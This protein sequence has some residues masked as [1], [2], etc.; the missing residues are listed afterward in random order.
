MWNYQVYSPGRGLKGKKKKWY[1]LKRPSLGNEE[2]DP[3]VGC[4]SPAGQ[5]RVDGTN[6]K[7]GGAWILLVNS[8]QTLA[9]SW[10]RA[11]MAIE[12]PAGWL[13]S[14]N[15]PIQAL[16]W[17]EQMLWHLLFCIEAL[18]WR[19]ICHDHGKIILERLWELNLCS[20]R[21]QWGSHYWQ[22]HRWKSE[23][24]QISKNHVP[25][26]KIPTQAPLTPALVSSRT[27]YM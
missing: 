1:Y 20:I 23:A 8:I 11:E 7:P 12:S 15:A 26:L 5:Q 10:R 18:H 24:D 22:L 21:T 9:C 14:Q 3:H 25:T 13:V 17:V 4:P 19:D 16:A 2:L 27:N 6:R